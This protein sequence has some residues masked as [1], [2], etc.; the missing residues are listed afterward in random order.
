[1][2]RHDEEVERPGQLD[3]LTGIR[4][5][6]LSPCEPVGIAGREP[7]AEGACVHGER[8]V[9]V[10]V[11]EKRPRGEVAARVRRVR[12]LRGVNLFKFRLVGLTDVR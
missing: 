8:R 5:D 7:R 10:R 12:R 6:L 1:M 3:R 4:G 11:A 2:V 9:Q